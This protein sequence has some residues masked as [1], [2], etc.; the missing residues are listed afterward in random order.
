MEKVSTSNLDS[1]ETKK[2]TLASNFQNSKN[3]QNQ[4]QR[5]IS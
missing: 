5:V 4:N 2:T 3:Q 1:S